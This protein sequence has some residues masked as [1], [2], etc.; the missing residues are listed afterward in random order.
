VQEWSKLP[1]PHFSAV[2]REFNRTT[3]VCKHEN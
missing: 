1:A 2:G 3:Q